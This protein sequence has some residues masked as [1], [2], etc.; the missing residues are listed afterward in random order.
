MTQPIRYNAYLLKSNGESFRYVGLGEIIHGSGERED[1]YIFCQ[2]V[3]GFQPPEEGRTRFLI[4]EK[5]DFSSLFDE[6]SFGELTPESQARK[7]RESNGN[8][9]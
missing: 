4:C 1:V 2:S 9:A 5:A 3:G 8:E 6:S 7:E